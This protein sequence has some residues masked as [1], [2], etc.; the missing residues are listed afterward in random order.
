MTEPD[1]LNEPQFRGGPLDGD[2]VSPFQQ[3]AVRFG[4]PLKVPTTLD[5]TTALR[6]AFGDG[7]TVALYRP[8]AHGDFEYIGESVWRPFGDPEE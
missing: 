3:M 2:P 1:E 4:A 7:C 5:A 8:N 6:R